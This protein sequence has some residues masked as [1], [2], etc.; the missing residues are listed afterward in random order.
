M[1]IGII[2]PSKISYVEEINPNARKII[3]G[4]AKIVKD[5]EIV[6]T[7]DK[8]SVSEFFAEKYISFGG[9]KIYS[10]IPLDDHEFGYSWLNTNLGE[11]INCGSWR[12]Q[13]EKLNEETE[14]L[15]C[16]GYSVGGNIEISYSKWFNKKPVYIIRE[17]VTAEFP[18]DATRDLDIKYISYKDFS[19][20]LKNA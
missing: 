17:L 14:V 6:L 10:I 5:Y 8:G 3:D 20:E 13:P 1:K 16:L 19:K 2:G 15:L 11:H 4:L 18:R 9:K 12:N 7:P